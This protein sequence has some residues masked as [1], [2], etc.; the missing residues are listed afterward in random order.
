MHA[1]SFVVS[2]AGGRLLRLCPSFLTCGLLLIV[3]DLAAQLAP[4]ASAAPAPKEEEVVV[5]Q[6]F[7]VDGSNDTRYR[8]AST[9]A[10]SR[11]NSDLKDVASVIDVFTR[12]FMNDIGALNLEQVLA[13]ANNMENDTEDTT[14]GL[15]HINISTNNSFRYR[16]RGLPASRARN[17]FDFDYPIDTYNTERLDESRGPNSILFGF[18]SPG[19]IVN[20]STKQPL[21]RRNHAIV[22]YVSG[23]E[24]ENRFTL[25]VNQRILDDRLAVRFNGLYQRKEGW[26]EYTHEDIDAVHFAVKAKPFKKTTVNAEFERFIQ[27]DAVARPGTYWSQTDTWDAAGKTLINTN[28]ANRNNATLNPGLAVPTIAQLSG[29]NYWIFTEQ[30]GNLLNWRGMS[31]SNRASYTNAAGQTFTAFS[32]MRQMMLTPEGILEVNTMGPGA[33]RTLELDAFFASMQQE[34]SRDLHLEFALTKQYSDWFSRRL[35]ASTLFADPNAFLPVGGSAST[36]P[37]S[38]NPTANPFK[39]QYY[40]ETVAQFWRTTTDTLNYR[41]TASY[42]FKLPG[43]LGKHRIGLLWEK[44]ELET[45]TKALQEQVMLNGLPVSTLPA[46]AANNL[47]RRYYIT[48]GNTSTYR[49]SNVNLPPVPLYQTLADGT[50][51]STRFIQY[52][53]APGDYTKEDDILMVVLQSKWWGDRFSTII[54]VRQDDVVFDDWGSY[55]ADGMGGYVRSDANRS[56]V[57]YDG[58]TKNYGVVYTATNWLSV[59]ANYSTSLG[60]PGLKVIYA[61]NGAFMDPMEGEGTDI[62][63]KFSIPK[64]RI[65]GMVTYYEASSTNETDNQNVEGWAVN[66]MNSFLDGL[67]TAGLMTTTEATPLRSTGTGDTVD[68]ESSGVELSLTG[69][70]TENWDVRFNYSYTERS[71]SNAFPRVNAWATDVLRPLW[72]RFDRDNP[73]TPAADN[74]LDT[75]LSGSNTLRTLINNFESNLATRTLS[76]SRV[77]G[78]RPH[79]ANV[80]TTYAFKDGRLKGLRL[81][82]GIRYDAAN[83]AGVDATTGAIVRGRSFTNVDLM[84]AYTRKLFDHPCT[85]Q[86]NVR[87]ALRDEAAVSPSVINTS[88]TWESI[89]ISPPRQITLTLRLAY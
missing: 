21:L 68:S 34:V 19:G 8:A 9:L 1:N 18:G 35:P 41:A 71:L 33:G 63:L 55:V 24:V 10:G 89:I 73:N 32:D 52:T 25:D 40:L 59:F 72:A 44:D 86:L 30:N 57:P 66:G 53:S 3:P 67:V 13:Y 85:I 43:H 64:F 76:R 80:F 77:T 42:D 31:R 58:L 11:L 16:I 14:H 61:P 79:K 81:G 49:N 20:L 62:G 56:F 27:N 45:R 88:G 36:G 37:A 74:I 46:N 65:E 84:A 29:S 48:P 4:A 5:L 60:V 82:G 23:T 7:E 75:V 50:N 12:D 15:G 83:Y 54:G 6:P 26:R 51:F 39:G 78:L 38:V 70:L 87:D 22:E 47:V 2:F 17:F 28:F 69:T